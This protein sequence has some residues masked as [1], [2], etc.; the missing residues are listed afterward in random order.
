MLTI[1]SNNRITK[2]DTARV[3]D[4]ELH[5]PTT[6]YAALP[7]ASPLTH[8]LPSTPDT[9]MNVSAHCCELQ[10]PALHNGQ[11][12][13]WALGASAHERSKALQSLHAPD[14][15]LTDLNG[16]PHSLSDYRGQK[17]FLASWSSW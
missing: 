4:D 7:L 8:P 6:E 2:S 11:G 14:F 17:I 1:L 5:M 12:D 9:L 15:T 13:V 3:I 16:D 10:R